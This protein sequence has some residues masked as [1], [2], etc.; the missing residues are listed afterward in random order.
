MFGLRKACP[1]GPHGSGGRLLGSFPFLESGL[2]HVQ[3]LLDCAQRRDFLPVLLIPGLRCLPAWRHRYSVPE[4]ADEADFLPFMTFNI[5]SVIILELFDGDS[6]RLDLRHG[7]SGTAVEQTRG[8]QIG[9]SS[10]K[11]AQDF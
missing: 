8:R 4:P 9:L 6:V 1:S 5:T 11:Y 2:F 10:R 7:C 3:K